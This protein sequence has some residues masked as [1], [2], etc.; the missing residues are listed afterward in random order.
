MDR[1]V[2]ERLKLLAQPFQRRLKDVCSVRILEIQQALVDDVEL[3]NQVVEAVDALVQT[4][5][6]ALIQRVAQ[7][8]HGDVGGV[9]NPVNGRPGLRLR[10]NGTFGKAQIARDRHLEGLEVIERVG[11]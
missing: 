6:A 5:H 9:D 7:R 11:G 4:R 1:T 2:F 8:P 3:F 10:R